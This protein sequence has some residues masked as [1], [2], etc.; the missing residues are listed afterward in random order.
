MPNA[1]VRRQDRITCDEEERLRRGYDIE[2][3]FRYATDG[4]AQRRVEAEVV[5]DGSNVLSL[6]Y[7]PAATLVREEP[8]ASYSGLL[9]ALHPQP[10]HR[11]DRHQYQPD[12][13]T[14]ERKPAELFL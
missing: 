2:V 12:R 8:S 11:Q 14:I 9:V 7:A 13:G 5:C 3:C 10:R 4:G 1:R 6:V